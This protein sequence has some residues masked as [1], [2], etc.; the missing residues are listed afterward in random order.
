MYPTKSS[1]I[2]SAASGSLAAGDRWKRHTKE[3][4]DS[5]VVLPLSSESPQWKSSCTSRDHYDILWSLESIGAGKPEWSRMEKCSCSTSC[6]HPTHPNSTKRII[7]NH[8][9]HPNPHH[10]SCSA[11]LTRWCS[12]VLVLDVQNVTGIL[13]MVLGLIQGA[14]QVTRRPPGLATCRNVSQC[15]ATCQATIQ[16]MDICSGCLIFHLS[17]SCQ[18]T[19]SSNQVAF[20]Q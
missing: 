20:Q 13:V 1:P 18:T 16:Q 14:L 4:E 5:E 9:Y 2:W 3:K 11:R 8:P 10:V 6:W 7:M 17:P 15:V 12:F 19:S